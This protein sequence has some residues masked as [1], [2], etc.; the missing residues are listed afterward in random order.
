MSYYQSQMSNS[1]F[2]DYAS[3]LGLTGADADALYESYYGYD[4]DEYEY[5]MIA[6]SMEY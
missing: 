6:E 4:Q 2:E 3:A 5:E 1:D